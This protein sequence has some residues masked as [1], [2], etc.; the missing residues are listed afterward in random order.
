MTHHSEAMRQAAIEAVDS[1]KTLL[2]KMKSISNAYRTHRE[3]SVQEAV[4]IVL[5]EIWLR[6][7]HPVVMFANSNLPEKRYRICRSEEEI[8][9]MPSDST[10]IFKKNMLDRY[11]DRPNRTFKNGKYRLIDSM[12]FAE[13]L[14]NYYLSVKQKSEERNDSQPEILEDLIQ[15]IPN[16]NGFPKTIPL[17]SS[18]ETLTLRKEKCVLYEVC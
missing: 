1:G 16:E 15:E 4:S 7:T 13:F 17:M 2:E 10:D 5:Q 3:M 18:K 14:S 11:T 9:N 12:C 6:K 8:T